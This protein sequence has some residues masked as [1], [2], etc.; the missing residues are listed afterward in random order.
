M[1]KG[2]LLIKIAIDIQLRPG[3]EKRKKLKY[4]TFGAE[5]VENRRKKCL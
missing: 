3:H 5:I 4:I 1:I 2:G